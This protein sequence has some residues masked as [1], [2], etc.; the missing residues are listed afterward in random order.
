SPSSGPTTGGTSVTITGSRF[1][2]AT[3]VKFGANDATAF[4]VN[5]DAQITATSPAG[6]AGVVDVTVTTAS[7]P[8]AIGTNDKFTYVAGGAA[9]TATTNSATGVTAYG[10]TLIGSVTVNGASTT[11]SSDYGLK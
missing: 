10:A 4:T 6:V 9:P 1:T 3:A 8:S 2:G 11:V 5:S 7:G